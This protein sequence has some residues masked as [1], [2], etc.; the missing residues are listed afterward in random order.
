MSKGLQGYIKLYR[1]MLDW[2]WYD[3][4]N[5]KVVFLHLLLTA[6]FTDTSWHGIDVRRGQVI[7]SLDS[8]ASAV[9]LTKSQVRTALKHL[10]S[11][12]EITDLRTQNFRLITL[13]NFNK[14][15]SSGT[16][17]S[18]P[19]STPDDRPETDQSHSGSTPVSD[20]SHHR[21]NVKNDNNYKNYNNGNKKRAAEPPKDT[22]STFDVY[23][24]MELGWFKE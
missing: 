7:T 17:G 18:T 19:G 2:E 1:S 8:I 22:N 14:Y 16:P 24:L 20:H 3:D 23:E 11:T 21:K 13:N 15:Q 9:G 12:D 5:T 10:K 6:S 4:V